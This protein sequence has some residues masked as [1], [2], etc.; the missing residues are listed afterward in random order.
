MEQT[1]G[2]KS[3]LRM[4]S[5]CRRQLLRNLTRGLEASRTAP[6]SRAVGAAMT[7][8]GAGVSER[9]QVTTRALQRERCKLR[10]APVCAKQVMQLQWYRRWLQ[11]RGRRPRG[12][13]TT[14]APQRRRMRPMQQRRRLTQRTRPPPLL[15]RQPVWS[16]SQTVALLKALTTRALRAQNLTTR[17]REGVCLPAVGCRHYAGAT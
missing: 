12:T 2:G 3:K 8:V 6:P 9:A 4:K 5:S 7:A 1:A 16:G 10:C 15:M 11:R 14:S 13:G 17:S